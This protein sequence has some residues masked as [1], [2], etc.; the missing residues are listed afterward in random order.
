M[1]RAAAVDARDGRLFVSSWCESGRSFVQGDWIEAVDEPV[2]DGRLGTLV[3]SALAASHSVPWPDFRAGP[4]PERQRLLKL[5]K[6]KSEAQYMRG[7]R[8]VEVTAGDTRP[9]LVITPYHNGGRREG[10][11]EMLDQEAWISADADDAA[12]GA[13]VRRALASAADGT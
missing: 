3:R 5:A 9:G 2:E 4:T 13:A 1:E 12:I 10:F 11:T 6:V 7:T 8:H